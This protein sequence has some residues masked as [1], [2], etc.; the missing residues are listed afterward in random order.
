MKSGA[1]YQGIVSTVA[2]A[3]K[4]LILFES[5]THSYSVQCTFYRKMFAK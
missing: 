3:T 2:L 5:F 4:Y 1:R